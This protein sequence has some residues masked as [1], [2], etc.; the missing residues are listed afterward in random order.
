MPRK[1]RV[2]E[3]NV[4]YHVFNRRNDRQLLFPT[5][6]SRDAF[7]DLLEEGRNGY[8]VAICMYCVMETHWHQGLWVRDAREVTAVAG[9]IRWLSSRH[10]IRFRV[11]T[12]TRGNGHVYQDRYK[13]KPVGTAEHYITLNRYI[14]ANPLE[15]GLVDR[16]EDW[17]WCSLAERVSGRRRII[18]DGPVPL[19]SNWLE[20]VN[21]KSEFD[22]YLVLA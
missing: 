15:A 2:L 5:P 17:R 13:S 4:V 6:R 10:A 1:P 12:G 7:V 20:I 18:T 16:A 9:Y 14:E 19:P 8:R 3:P 21:R 11:G 22:D